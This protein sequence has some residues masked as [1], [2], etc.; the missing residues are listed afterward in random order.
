MVASERLFPNRQRTLVERLRLGETALGSVEVREVVERLRNVGMGSTERV[1]PDRKRTFE[2]RLRLSETTLVRV[3]EP[4]IVKAKLRRRD[5]RRRATFPRSPENARR[6]AL[7]RR[8]GPG[9]R[10]GAQGC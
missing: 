4:E 2:E 1:F 9:L 10:G 6:A 5:D 3:E 8:N 7:P